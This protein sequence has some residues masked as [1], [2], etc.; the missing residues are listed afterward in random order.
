[1][2]RS[3]AWLAVV[4]FCLSTQA[5]SDTA[6]PVAAEASPGL[7][8]APAS[9]VKLDPAEAEI[10]RN[11]AKG[12]AEQKDW[13]SAREQAL[14]ATQ[15][16]PG[17]ADAW[18]VLG[19]AEQRLEHAAAARDAFRK[20]L[21]MNPP[22]DKAAFVR[23][24][25][26]DLEVAAEKQEKS[27]KEAK[28]TK[29]GRKAK[30]LILGFAPVYSTKLSGPNQLGHGA[31]NAFLLGIRMDDTSALLLR[32]QG[33]TIPVLTTS[34]PTSNPGASAKLMTIAFEYSIT[35]NDP[36][37]NF[38]GFQFFIPIN[39]QGYL[40]WLTGSTNVYMNFGISAGVGAGVRYYTGGPA[41]FDLSFLYHSAMSFGAIEQ[42]GTTDQV[43]NA[44]GKLVYGTP[45]GAEL[46]LSATIVF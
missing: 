3:R 38:Y 19:T 18:L 44:A 23:S 30:G 24:R 14:K 16:D 33:A 26:A 6:A 20:Y 27:A 46:R 2:N 25:V 32:Y 37:D 41:I 40:N 4:V 34:A 13:K 8:A 1:M 28:E 29:Y 31:S 42:A 35:L 22:A 7:V 17:N 21:S 9:A 39:L 12:F 36:F 10:A 11:K 15:L 45:T 43:V 5:F